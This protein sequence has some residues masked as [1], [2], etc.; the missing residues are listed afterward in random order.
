MYCLEAGT[1][2]V[3]QRGTDSR[4]YS[5]AWWHTTWSPLCRNNQRTGNEIRQ[6]RTDGLGAVARACNPTMHEAEAGSS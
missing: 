4:G 3:K 2:L 5:L 6:G 1:E